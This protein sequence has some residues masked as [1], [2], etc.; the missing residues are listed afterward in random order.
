MNWIYLIVLL[1]VVYF[2]YGFLKKFISGS[3]GNLTSF[4]DASKSKSV[5]TKKLASGKS[6]TNLTWAI[7]IYVSDWQMGSKKTIMETDSITMDLGAS[8]NDLTVKVNS[9]GGGGGGTE[10][11]TMLEG[12]GLLE[13]MTSSQ[14]STASGDGSGGSGDGSGGSGDGSGGDGKG[15]DGKGGDGKGGDGKGGAGGGAPGFS[16]GKSCVVPNIPIQ[17]WVHCLASVYG[18]SVDVYVDGKLVKTCLLGSL[19]STKSGTDAHVTPGGGFKGFTSKLRF[20]PNAVN[21]QEA[22]NIYKEGPG[23]PMGTG[24]GK[25]GG[26]GGFGGLSGLKGLF[27]GLNLANLFPTLRLQLELEKNGKDMGSITV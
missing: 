13:G 25:M 23:A 6:S 11:F 17:K 19:V 10:S 14:N 27:S 26:L 20:I 15:G 8:K 2:A 24:M 3:S 5:S 16:G 9:G 22:Y 12:F 21:P 7:W 18:K 1:V 4:A